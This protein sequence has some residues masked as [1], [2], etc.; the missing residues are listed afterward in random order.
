MSLSATSLRTQ[1]ASVYPCFS[2][3]YTCYM[4]EVQRLAGFRQLYLTCHFE[5]SAI[6]I[7]R[8]SVNS[9]SFRTYPFS[10]VD[11]LPFFRTS[12]TISFCIS[13]FSLYFSFPFFLKLIS[14]VLVSAQRCSTS[15][16][17]DLAACYRSTFTVNAYM[18]EHRSHFN[19]FHFSPS[20]SHGSALVDE[21]SPGSCDTV[22]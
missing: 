19:S 16:W 6:E 14:G 22:A 8:P 3:L 1:P 7:I 20:P 10:L 21:K 18:R 5:H 9:A 17:D 13:P 11:S 15:H 4:D 12:S 2:S